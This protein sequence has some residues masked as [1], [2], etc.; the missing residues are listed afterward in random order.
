MNTLVMLTR[1]DKS[2]SQPFMVDLGKID[3]FGPSL[4]RANDRRSDVLVNGHMISVTE[5]VTYIFVLKYLNEMLVRKEL[6]TVVY[7]ISH[8]DYC[9]AVSCPK[10]N[11]K[12]VIYSITDN[13]SDFPCKDCKEE[14]KMHSFLDGTYAGV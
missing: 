13:V 8:D 2:G 4:D 7:S 10:H 11:I 12:Q 6:N 14:V 1:I 5:P 9:T 3:G